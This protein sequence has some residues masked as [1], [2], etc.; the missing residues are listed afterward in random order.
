MKT[1][2]YILYSPSYDKYYV[3]Q[4]KDLSNR[5]ERHNQ[6]Y[7]KF[8]SFYRPW[9]LVWYASKPTRADAMVLERKLKNLT[10]DRLREFIKKY[11]QA[12]T[13]PL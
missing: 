6:G 1:F 8:T 12:G 13:N 10:K 9:S 11:S 7:E 5:V 2:V 4:T 3:G